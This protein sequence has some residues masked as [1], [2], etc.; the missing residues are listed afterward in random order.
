MAARIWD[1]TYLLKENAHW[2]N[3]E[4]TTWDVRRQCSSPERGDPIWKQFLEAI[5]VKKPVT[6]W[7]IGWLGKSGQKGKS[8]TDLRKGKT[9]SEKTHGETWQSIRKSKWGIGYM[10]LKGL[11]FGWCG[12]NMK[13]ISYM[14]NPLGWCDEIWKLYLTYFSFFKT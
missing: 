5:I 4:V 10:P 6:D 7:L 3:F 9:K 13:A 12:Q 2:H 11:P 1:G 14:L 8:Q